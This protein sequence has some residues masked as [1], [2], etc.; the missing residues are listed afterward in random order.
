[1]P[2]TSD[3]LATRPHRGAP[4]PHWYWRIRDDR[5]RKLRR[6]RLVE[7][8]RR[9][10]HGALAL[11]AIFPQSL[12]QA[13]V[14]ANEEAAREAVF[15]RMQTSIDGPLCHLYIDRYGSVHQLAARRPFHAPQHPVHAPQDAPIPA[16][17]RRIL[18]WFRR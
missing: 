16:R 13:A 14:V 15:Q 18:G 7:A 1:M 10:V 5:E 4:M 17:W 9:H 2:I 6:H 3:R 11:P 8:A 12:I